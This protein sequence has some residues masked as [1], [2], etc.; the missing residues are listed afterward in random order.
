MT[1]RQNLSFQ[2]DLAAALAMSQQT[3]KSWSQL[4]SSDPILGHEP[5]TDH[6]DS[7]PTVDQVSLDDIMSEQLALEMTFNNVLQ[8]S[9]TSEAQPLSNMSDFLKEAGITESDLKELDQPNQDCSTD[10]DAALA[11]LLQHELDLEHDRRLKLEEKQYNANSKVKISFENQRRVKDQDLSYSDLED[12]EAYHEYGEDSKHWD[13]FEKSERNSVK[14]GRQ[15]FTVSN[16]QVTTKHDIETN[17]C[18]NACKVMEFESDINT[19]DGGGFAMKIN[20]SVYNALK[21]HSI[22]EGKRMARLHEKKEKSSA[23]KAID[24]KSRI[25]LFK[26]IDRG[27]LDSINGIIATGKESVVVHAV[28]E[29]PEKGITMGEVAIKIFKTTITEFQNRVQYIIGDPVLEQAGKLSRQNP[30][31]TIPLWAEKEMHN[32]NRMRKNGIACPEVVLL[33][34]HILIMSFIGKDGRAAPT[35]KNLM[36]SPELVEK[37]WNQ[38]VSLMVKLYREC[39]LIHADLSEYNLMWHENKLWCIDVSQA[40]RITHPMSF[41][42]LWRDCTNICKFFAKKMP[43]TLTPKELFTMITGKD[44]SDVEDDDA[45]IELF[46]K[47]ENYEKNEEKLTYNQSG[48]DIFDELFEKSLKDK[49]CS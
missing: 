38:T 43:S 3:N 33:K 37:V 6:V 32:L 46:D 14:V 34:K 31:L 28:G 21:V 1:S 15:G 10:N 5:L 9:E 30:K 20:N 47:M 35:L 40:V 23:E 39:D 25:L 7:P 42:F 24:E 29:N 11:K 17:K 48:P 4:V 16:G 45:L 13:F 22:S 26:L 49:S 18:R 36:F 8:R 19:G 44:I 2:R 41:R 12:E 27:I